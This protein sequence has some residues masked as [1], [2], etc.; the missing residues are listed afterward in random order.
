MASKKIQWGQFNP[1]IVAQALL[2]D[3]F[4]AAGTIG[5]S[6]FV[7]HGRESARRPPSEIDLTILE[8]GHESG[9]VNG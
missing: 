3:S 1:E 2:D 6:D 4:I 5:A 7:N 9:I 8:S